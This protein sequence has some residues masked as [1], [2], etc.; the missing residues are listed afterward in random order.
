M[1][2]ASVLER[3]INGHGDA[4]RCELQAARSLSPEQHF[5][6]GRWREEPLRSQDARRSGNHADG[7]CDS[8]RSPCEHWFGAVLRRRNALRYITRRIHT[9]TCARVARGF[10]RISDRET[11]ALRPARIMVSRWARWT[12]DAEQW[13]VHGAHL[14][15]VSHP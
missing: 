14:R 13:T 7:A 4:W 5:C 9:S 11:R 12:C 6:G 8:A 3:F 1:R 15:L 10:A 2:S